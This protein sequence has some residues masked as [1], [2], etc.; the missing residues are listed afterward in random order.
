MAP[1]EHPSNACPLNLALVGATGR[2]GSHVLRAAIARGHHVTVLVRDPSHLAPMPPTVRVVKGDVDDPAT[3]M[4]ALSGVDVLISCLGT[5]RG[6]EPL[7]ILAR[8]MTNFVAAAEATGKVRILA[9]AS[10]GLL[11]SPEGGLRRDRAGY[12]AAFKQGSAA[13]LAAYQV[14][15]ASNL[16]WT[17]ICPPELVEGA[18]EQ[19]IQWQRSQLPPGPLRVSMPALAAW[20][21]D[22]AQV[23]TQIGQRIGLNDVPPASL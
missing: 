8:A 1:S 14:L 23:P 17:L 2:L 19:P 6:Q 10:A 5:R 16:H 21:L 7:D 22:E 15:A 3:V 13:H 9:V 18:P 20:I 11:D 4:A 12:P